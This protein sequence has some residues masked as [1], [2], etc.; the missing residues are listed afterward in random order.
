M[1]GLVGSFGVFQAWSY[2]GCAFA[3]VALSL[4]MLK[5]WDRSPA[6]RRLI[7]C[8]VVTAVWSVQLALQ[9]YWVVSPTA[10]FVGEVVRPGLW[11]WFLG[12]LRRGTA[13]RLVEILSLFTWPLLL[14]AGLLISV[15]QF[16]QIVPEELLGHFLPL[17]G[18]ILSVLGLVTIEQFYRNTQLDA[19]RELRLL[20]LAIGMSFAYDLFLYSQ[21]ELLQVSTPDV[22]AVRGVLIAALTVLLLKAVN[23]NELWAF[24][25]FVSRQVVFHT[26]SF[27]AVGVYLLLMA[28][29]GYYIRAIGGA[30]GAILEMTFFAG[31]MLA[32]AVLLFSEV[33]RR[34]LMVFISKHFYSNK[35]DYRLEWL[36]FID[37]LSKG[38]DKDVVDTAV[39]AIVQLLESPGGLLYELDRSAGSFR[40]SGM[41]PTQM[42]VVSGFPSILAE[43][44]L[45]LFMTQREWVIDMA[46]Y[47]RTPEKYPGM[48]IPE[49]LLSQKDLRLLSPVL[50]RDQLLGF[51][52]IYDPPPPF[53]LTFE[54]RDLLKTAGRHIATQLSQRR[55]HLELGE[56]RQFQTYNRF[57]AFTM[58][59]L[60]NAVAQLNL[61]VANAERHKTNPEFVDDMIATIGNASERMTRLMEQLQTGDAQLQPRIVAVEPVLRAAIQRCEARLP[62]V[63]LT[64]HS[65]IGD[66]TINVDPE[67]MTAA[68][69]HLIRNAQEATVATGSVSLE[70]YVSGTQELLVLVSDDGIGMD[71]AFIRDRLFQPFDSTKGAQGMGIGAYQV[72]EY[73]QQAGGSIEVS[74]SP[75]TGTRFCITLPVAKT[76]VAAS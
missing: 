21:T 24:D 44:P 20:V 25:L 28:L 62:A 68:I 47:R 45:V 63:A 5:S 52:A 8:C 11:L 13:P 58:H 56:T 42:A 39:R 1:N 14:A 2:G 59:D 72:R 50:E 29:G 4:L 71:L 34:R 22:W 48:E 55:A 36:R 46:E 41:W 18:L 75:G 40:V 26:T 65:S 70:A 9:P 35:Y 32:L 16:Y 61:V 66:C 6:A 73:V 60:K 12:G 3:Y 33:W 74:S 17:S 64:L 51:L 43:H 49:F 10:I 67:R 38:G 23:R 37:T 54:D 15:L 31:A 53:E 57:I 19:R 69:E 30:W 76:D 7:I 27:S